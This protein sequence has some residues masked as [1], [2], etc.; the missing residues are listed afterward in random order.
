MNTNFP[1]RRSEQEIAWEIGDRRFATE[2]FFFYFINE[3]M[4]RKIKIANF[5]FLTGKE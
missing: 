1:R 5:N 3:M 4:I 2:A